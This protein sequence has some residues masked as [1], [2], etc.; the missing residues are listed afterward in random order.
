MIESLANERVVVA[1]LVV[2]ARLGITSLEYAICYATAYPAARKPRAG[3]SRLERVS[4][5]LLTGRGRKCRV[6][7]L[8]HVGVLRCVAARGGVAGARSHQRER[9]LVRLLR[10]VSA[11]TRLLQ[12]VL[13]LPAQQPVTRVPRRQ[14]RSPMHAVR[15]CFFARGAIAR[16]RAQPRGRVSRQT[17]LV[18]HPAARVRWHT[19]HV[20]SSRHEDARRPTRPSQSSWIGPVQPRRRYRRHIHQPHIFGRTAPAVH[21][22]LGGGHERSILLRSYVAVV[23]VRS[24]RRPKLISERWPALTLIARG[25]ASVLRFPVTM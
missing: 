23:L 13:Q 2:V 18:A 1:A 25:P 22:E 14:P 8:S 21:R 16:H 15:M 5:L 20:V 7:R 24:G 3:M 4:R 12:V 6:R 9:Q 19:P 10:L 17:V 11:G